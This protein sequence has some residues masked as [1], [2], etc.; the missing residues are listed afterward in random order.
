MELSCWSL[1]FEDGFALWP[2]SMIITTVSKGFFCTVRCIFCNCK[3]N[4]VAWMS[5]STFFPPFS[6]KMFFNR[7]VICRSRDPLPD[8]SAVCKVF[9]TAPDSFSCMPLPP[10]PPAAATRHVTSATSTMP[11]V[12]RST[13][14]AV[15]ARETTDLKKKKKTNPGLSVSVAC[16]L[17]WPTSRSSPPPTVP[18]CLQQ[19]CFQVLLL[20]SR[21][22][23]L[24]TCFVFYSLMQGFFCRS[25][26]G[27]VALQV[28]QHVDLV[29]HMLT[30][31]EAGEWEF[32]FS[33]QV[34]CDLWH[35]GTQ[36]LKKASSVYASS[37]SA[38]TSGLLQLRAF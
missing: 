19:L 21:K 2:R 28:Q 16:V 25:W 24:H 33:F 13:P 4:C 3:S 34:C 15:D 9:I 31:A 27:V 17:S 18:P 35:A 20:L 36:S 8:M 29:T 7:P 12:V 22:K 6:C 37:R 5:L 26:N 11:Y 1:L 32:V 14:R 38:V 23:S 10:H 30:C